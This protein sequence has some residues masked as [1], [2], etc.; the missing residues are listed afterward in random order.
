MTDIGVILVLAC[1]VLAPWLVR[2]AR[3]PARR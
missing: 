3:A 2:L 1:A